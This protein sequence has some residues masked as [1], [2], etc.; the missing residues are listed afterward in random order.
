MSL[1]D[2][3]D[4]GE[5]PSASPM[6]TSATTLSSSLVRETTIFSAGIYAGNANGFL[7]DEDAFGAFVATAATTGTKTPVL[8]SRMPTPSSS[9]RTSFAI[10]M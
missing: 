1:S 10:A 4:S 2:A 3:E 6:S 5:S 8:L 9:L 7:R